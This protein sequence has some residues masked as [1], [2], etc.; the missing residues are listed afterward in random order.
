MSREAFNNLHAIL[1]EECG[2]KLSRGVESIEALGMFLL[3]CATGDCARGLQDTFRRSLD[4][5]HRKMAHV[6]EVMVRFGDKVICSKDPSYS[7]VSP[8][9]AKWSPFFD[10]CI[11]AIDGTQIEIVADKESKEDMRNRKGFPS[12]NVLAIV[13][14]AM[15]FTF[16]GSGMSGACHDMYVLRECQT[17]PRFP[18]PPPGMYYAADSGYQLAPGYLTPY[19]NTRYHLQQFVEVGPSTWEEKFNH[20]HASIRNVVERTFGVAKN[21]WQILDG[22]PNYKRETQSSIIVACCALHNYLVERKAAKEPQEQGTPVNRAFV[23]WLAEL[24]VQ[25]MRDW[26]KTGVAFIDPK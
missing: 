9:V 5:I 15:R 11:G 26:I 23:E 18:K 8:K 21:R 12:F 19:K 1:V 2:L 13:D 20:D 17:K 10:G 16:V 7:T 22:I 25:E 14:H 3:A 6:A 4:T 24:P